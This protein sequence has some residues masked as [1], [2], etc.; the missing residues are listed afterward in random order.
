MQKPIKTVGLTPAH[1]L[2]AACAMLQS[3]EARVEYSAPGENYA[4]EIFFHFAAGQ[5]VEIFVSPPYGQYIQEMYLFWR[6]GNGVTYAAAELLQHE[7]GIDTVTMFEETKASDRLR[8]IA[9]IEG[10]GL[11]LDDPSLG[12]DAR[13]SVLL[14]MI[15]KI[16]MAEADAEQALSDARSAM[17]ALVQV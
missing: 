12:A 8:V 13:I 7:C 11:S 5:S 17:P 2:L 3:Q 16:V 4:G 6:H 9:D 14:E 1:A 10:E 15:R